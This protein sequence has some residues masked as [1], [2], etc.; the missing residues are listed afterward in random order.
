MVVLVV[1]VEVVPLPPLPP[2]QDTNAI[3][4]P[5]LVDEFPSVYQHYQ[6]WSWG[7]MW[8]LVVL[9]K[10]FNRQFAALY[11]NLTHWLIVQVALRNDWPVY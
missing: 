1:V 8:T 5:G 6:C 10:D 4:S 2:Q 3:H 7:G 9:S 11:N